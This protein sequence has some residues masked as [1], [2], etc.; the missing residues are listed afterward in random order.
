M[1]KLT[2]EAARAMGR[3]TSVAKLKASWANGRLGGRPRRVVRLTDGRVLRVELRGPLYGVFLLGGHGSE[4]LCVRQT[5]HEA[6]A[7]ML[8]LGDELEPAPGPAS[9]SAAPP[10]TS[11]PGSTSSGTAE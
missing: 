2:P 1:R 9:A 8:R 7:E 11:S 6:A 10:G 3:A 5:A 4:L